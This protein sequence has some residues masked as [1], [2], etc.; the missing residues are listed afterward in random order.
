[1]GNKAVLEYVVPPLEGFWSV[2]G[3]FKGGGVA[4]TDKSK[5]VWAVMIRQPDF[6]TTAIFEVA[7]TAL[8]KKKPEL[9]VAKARLEK[10]TEGL[11]VQVRHIGSYDDE[12][13]TVAAL[14]RFATENGYLIDIND[15]R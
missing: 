2:V 13:A 6:V 7:K 10:L 9:I 11:C 14:D 3:D 8:S 1:M 12:P 15:T 4:I 5:F